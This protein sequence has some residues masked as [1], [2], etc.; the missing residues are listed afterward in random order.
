MVGAV[1]YLFL[2]IFV[3]SKSTT[4]PNT[5][6]TFNTFSNYRCQDV[7]C[8]LNHITQISKPVFLPTA[9]CGLDMKS[10]VCVSRQGIQQ[11]NNI[12]VPSS[13]GP[14]PDLN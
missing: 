4:M 1:S 12:K 9:L 11:P 2:V 3:S 7:N 13:P 6:S 10:I 8:T 14:F 5:Q